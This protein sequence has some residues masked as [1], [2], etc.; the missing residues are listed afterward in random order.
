M[1]VVA[2]LLAN[3]AQVADRLLHVTGAGWNFYAVGRLPAEVSACLALVF[4]LDESDFGTLPTFTYSVTAKA[5][6]EVLSSGSMMVDTFADPNPEGTP[7]R[8]PAAL[9]FA[10][11]TREAGVFVVSVRSDTGETV[12]E[13]EFPVRLPIG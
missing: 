13:V 5:S 12:A 6:Q 3:N 11:V 8:A 2:Q 9:P 7:F 1:K 10:F 4:E